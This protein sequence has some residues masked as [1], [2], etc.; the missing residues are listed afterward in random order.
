MW[1]FVLYSIDDERD[2]FVR[3]FPSEGHIPSLVL[4]LIILL[5]AFPWLLVCCTMSRSVYELI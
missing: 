1:D 3:C 5:E 2:E 4:S